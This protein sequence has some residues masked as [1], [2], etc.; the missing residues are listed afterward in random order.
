M[1]SFNC[2]G[3]NLTI[4]KIYILL[5]YERNYIFKYLAYFIGI[6]KVSLGA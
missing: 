1:P 5:N 3:G 2:K 6:F 4:K